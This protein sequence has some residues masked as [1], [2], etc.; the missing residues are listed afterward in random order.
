MSKLK[1]SLCKESKESVM[2]NID[3]ILDAV[4]KPKFICE[5]CARVSNKKKYL[6]DPL[7]ISDIKR[8]DKG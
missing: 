1:K 8:T 7:R 6:C 3:E 4:K 2:A 5:K